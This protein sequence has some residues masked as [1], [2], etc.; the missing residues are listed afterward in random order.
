MSNKRLTFTEEEFMD[1]MSDARLFGTIDAKR[2]IAEDLLTPSQIH[3]IHKALSVLTDILVLD[4]EFYVAPKEIT[5]A[6][7]SIY[8][9][10][11]KTC[12]LLKNKDEEKEL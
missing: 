10:F 11:P 12:E 7:N 6:Y 1:E 2:D 5:Y 8:D 3:T 9:N 4:Q